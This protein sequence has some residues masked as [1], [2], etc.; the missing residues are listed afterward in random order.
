MDDPDKSRPRRPGSLVARLGLALAA[1]AAATGGLEL[2]GWALDGGVARD[3]LRAALVQVS[4]SRDP[5][6]DQIPCPWSDPRRVYV[7]APET[8]PDM[9]PFMAMGKAITSGF[10]KPRQVPLSLAQAPANRRLVFVVGGSAAFGFPYPV[11]QSLAARLQ[12]LLGPAYRVINAAQPGWTSGQLVE[13]LRRLGRFSPHAVVFFL[14]NNE[15]IHWNPEPME[16]AQ[17]RALAAWRLASRSHLLSRVI[18]GLN[19]HRWTPAGDP[20]LRENPQDRKDLFDAE[21]WPATRARFLENLEQNLGTMIR[22]SSTD[23]RRVFLLTMPFNYRLHPE[24]KRPQPFSLAPAR[25]AELRRRT[26]EVKRRLERAQHE[27][28]LVDADRA[29]V[30]EPRAP[31]LHHLRGELLNRM[32]RFPESEQAFARAREHTVGNLGSVLS[33]N[34]A[35]RRAAR[36]GGATLVDVRKLFDE[37]EH[38]GG[39]HFNRSLIHDECHPTPAG[40]R[41]MAEA[42][43][44]LLM[45]K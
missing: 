22:L 19:L 4:Q 38:G 13:L 15:W 36:Q 12:A 30:L 24:Y 17:R 40:H 9:G 26:A 27:E 8:G 11:E 43:S 44:R 1:L 37:H 41:L 33:V 45:Q 20:A 6:T 29:L 14:G 28:A 23:R 3:R 35:I 10:R 5:I 25:R 18:Y 42:V 31:L 16:P 21:A 34:R 7:R 2:A 39:R 32:A